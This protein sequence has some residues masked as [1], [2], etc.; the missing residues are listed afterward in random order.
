MLQ[1]VF[2]DRSMYMQ[3]KTGRWQE[4]FGK[5]TYTA[6]STT[7]INW[8]RFTK[9]LAARIIRQAIQPLTS[10]RKDVFIVDDTLRI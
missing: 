8:E 9:L 7:K 3:M 10:V 1:K 2:A 4:E 6:S 5:N